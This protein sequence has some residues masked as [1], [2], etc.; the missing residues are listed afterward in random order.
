MLNIKSN[1]TKN[2]KKLKFKKEHQTKSVLTWEEN[3]GL[4]ERNTM[5]DH[6]F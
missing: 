4:S 1:Y 3:D 5:Q 6:I 2:N